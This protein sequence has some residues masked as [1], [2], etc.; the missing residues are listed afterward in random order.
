[1]THTKLRASFLALAA[2]AVAFTACSD[3]NVPFFTAPTSVPSTPP[4]VQN[5]MTGL[6]AGS[7]NDVQSFILDMTGY[8]RQGA[9]FT[10]TEPRFITY[11]LGV[12]PIPSQSGTIWTNAFANILQAHQI[13]AT[14][15]SV[16][17]AYTPAQISALT[18]VVQ[19][20]I[21][22]NYMHMQIDHDS[23]GGTI[24]PAT[25]AANTPLPAA[26][27]NQDMWKYIVALLDSGNAQLNTAGATPIPV[28][29][30][31]GFS[32]VSQ[33]AGPSTAAGSFAAFNRALAGKANFELAYALA[34]GPGGS[35][36]T[37]TT[38]GSP[39]VAALTRADSALTNSAL[40]APGALAAGPAGSWAADAHS[41]FWDFSATSG[42]LVN[43]MN[44]LVGTYVMLK[45]FVTLV[46]TADLRWKAKFAPYPA[47]VQQPT[48]APVAVQVSYAMY[49]QPGSLIPIVRNEGLVLWRAQIQLG[50]G[51]L[52]T[53]AA[54]TD[55]VRT[56][57][58]GEPAGTT[59]PTTV[60]NSL[61][62]TVTF[63]KVDPTSYTSVRDYIMREQQV[64]TAIEDNG[65]RTAA[66][67]DYRLE[68][69]A[70]TTWDSSNPTIKKAAPNG[71]QHTTVDPIPFAELS[72]RGGAFNKTCP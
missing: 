38:P 69:V 25:T 10:N 72:A 31:N 59:G 5:G 15:P 56:T 27:C 68:L 57:V 54:L 30:P 65:D 34:R 39:N 3:T 16:I 11:D 4:G 26:L 50:L 6:F 14:L 61:G 55:Q 28:K 12:V 35:A 21:A 47:T 22:Y 9:N 66:I 7:R 2:A 53:A 45:E 44:A 8:G 20:M 71:D 36:P 67:R 42:D 48:Y 64:S 32:A 13:L 52:A 60:R 58:G 43:P 46:D 18:G 29:L 37:A 63:A 19:T 40:Y 51:N 62:T 17:P 41:V 49:D 1:M 24:Q 23:G 70:D 33:V